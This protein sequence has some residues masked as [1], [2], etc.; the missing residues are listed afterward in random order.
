VKNGICRLILFIF[1]SVLFV[2]S[3]CSN[4][5]PEILQNFWEITLVESPDSTDEL[6]S[7]REE[8]SV[9]TVSRDEDGDDDIESIFLIQDEEELFWELDKDNWEEIDLQGEKWTGASSLL[10][11]ADESFPRTSYR[12]LVID[13]SGQRDEKTIAI[14]IKRILE[15][16][17]FPRLSRNGDEWEIESPHAQHILR[18]YDGNGKLKGQVKI[19]KN[20]FSQK[21]LREQLKPSSGDV[22]IVSA[23]DISKGWILQALPVKY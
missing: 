23:Q 7:F 14:S 18:I 17:E 11:P 6:V 8:L 12:V 5:P 4:N 20:S 15:P 1:I 9:F 3:A 22:L 10:M 13:K 16:P 19:D 2:L 21:F